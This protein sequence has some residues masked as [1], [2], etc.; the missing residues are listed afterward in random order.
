MNT[1]LPGNNRRKHAEMRWS[2][3]HSRHIIEN[4]GVNDIHNLL[5]EVTYL[6]RS[7]L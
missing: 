4:I 7:C 6:T 5:V 3:V 2:E 1:Q